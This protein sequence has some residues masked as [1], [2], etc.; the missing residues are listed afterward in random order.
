MPG[1]HEVPP[2]ALRD[3]AGVVSRCRASCPTRTGPGRRGRGT[4]GRLGEDRERDDQ[5]RVGEDQ[6]QHVGQDVLAHDPADAR[7]PASGRARRTAARCSESTW[8]RTMRDVPAQPVIASTITMMP[9]LPPGPSASRVV[10]SS[11]AMR[12]ANGRNG[13]T[14]NQSSSDRQRRG[15]PS[16]R[17]SRRRCRRSPPMHGRDEGR[18]TKPTTSEMRAPSRNC[19]SRSRPVSSVPSQCAAGRALHAVREGEAARRRAA[20]AA[21]AA[22]RRSPSRTTIAIVIR[23]N[24]PIG[25][26]PIA[27]TV[28]R[29]RPSQPAERLALGAEQA[30]DRLRRDRHQR[31]RTR[32]SRAMMS[33]SATRFMRITAADES[34][35]TPCSSGQVAVE[36]RVVG[37]PA[38]FPATR[39]PTR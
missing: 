5:H 29:C 8:L 19:E 36:Q 25:R 4:R 28:A 7:R 11:D 16:R 22:V 12:I 34:R 30:C 14:R 18:A 23:P 37:E 10:L 32:G 39:T 26:R 33:R 1:R 13:I 31:A 27:R 17:S 35:K 38:R 2:R 9:V 20:P 15:R 3:R 21:R 6:R 24:A